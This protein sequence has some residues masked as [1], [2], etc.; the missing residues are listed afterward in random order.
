VHARGA[1]R[2]GGWLLAWQRRTLL[3]MHVCRWREQYPTLSP[4]HCIPRQSCG[5]MLHL[6]AHD[7]QRAERG[8]CRHATSGGACECALMAL[9]FTHEVWMHVCI[10]HD[11]MLPTCQRKNCAWSLEWEQSG[12]GQGRDACQRVSHS[13]TFH[14]QDCFAFVRP[15]LVSHRMCDTRVSLRYLLSVVCV[16]AGWA[17]GHSA[18]RP[19]R[20]FL[21]CALRRV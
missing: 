19:R 15:C 10:R 20:P 17:A 16:R 18:G 4:G 13:N 3:Y 2:R 1:V 12:R 14:S 6:C 9:L 7:S 8:V 21:H 5:G 11:H